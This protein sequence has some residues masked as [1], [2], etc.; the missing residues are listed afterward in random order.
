MDGNLDNRFLLCINTLWILL[1]IITMSLWNYALCPWKPAEFAVYYNKRIFAVVNSAKE[2]Q[3]LYKGKTY[4]IPE[5]QTDFVNAKAYCEEGGGTLAK[6]SL[7]TTSDD[8]YAPFSQFL[9][10]HIGDI[11]AR[12]GATASGQGE[13]FWTD[14]NE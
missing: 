8:F 14:G 12:I 3:H 4:T 9:S 11:C 6:I 5:I 1:Q 10:R 7:Q 2:N 13:W